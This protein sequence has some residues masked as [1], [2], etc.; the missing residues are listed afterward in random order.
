MPAATSPLVLP[1]HAHGV[2][3]WVDLHTARIDDARAFYEALLDWTF[4]NRFALTA[5]PDQVT[6]GHTDQDRPV[7][8]VLALS[9]DEPVAD[10]V[11]RSGS[12]EELALLSTWY[13]Y[14]HVDDL[15]ATLAL[16]EPA[17]GLVLNPPARRGDSAMVAT[18][19]DPNDAMLSLW[20][21]LGHGLPPAAGHHPGALAWLELETPD[22]DTAR[23][24]YGELFGWDAGEVSLNDHDLG[25]TYTIFTRGGDRVAGAVESPIAGIPASWC[26]SFAVADAD[27]SAVVST[28]NGGVLLAEP[29]DIP[30]GRQAL[31]VDPTGAAFSILGPRTTGPRPL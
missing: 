5:V 21:P 3:N 19:L 23:K 22:L 16:V 20:E 2:P 31:I 4:Q 29:T 28:R 17:G 27:H 15:D 11:E 8:T 6:S 26:P 14:I 12:F 30:V 13:P 18:I 7:T 9:N 10:L 25:Q 24:F 1:L